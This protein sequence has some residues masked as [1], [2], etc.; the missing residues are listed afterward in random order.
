[1]IKKAYKVYSFEEYKNYFPP[2]DITDCITVF[3]ETNQKAKT[4]YLESHPFNDYIDLRA[5]RYPQHDLIDGIYRWILDADAE[6][7]AKKAKRV[8]FLESQSEETMFYIQNGYV[9]NSVLFWALGGSGYTSNVE[10]AQKYTKEEVLNKFV[11][12]REEDRIWV[13]SHVESK[14]SK[15]V[16]MQ[17][18]E[19]EFC[20]Y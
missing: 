13:A 12:G 11:G 4:K 10:K 2:L 17:Y 5:K 14:I 15:H 9:G 16:D 7:A 6:R 8:E 18:L 1:M 19:N 3:A 20:T